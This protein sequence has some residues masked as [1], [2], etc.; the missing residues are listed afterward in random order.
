VVA[1]RIGANRA[2]DG[3][4]RETEVAILRKDPFG[5]SELMMINLPVWV[6]TAVLFL[7]IL[8]FGVGF[9]LRRKAFGILLLALGVVCML[10]LVAYRVF[11]ALQT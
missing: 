1:S 7:G 11:L 3:L 2:A 6:S 4:T 10:T 9:S 5:S 8:L